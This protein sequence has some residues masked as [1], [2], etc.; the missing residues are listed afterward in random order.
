[1]DSSYNFK[2]YR[3]SKKPSELLRETEGIRERVLFDRLSHLTR[4]GLIVKRTK[5]G[6]P[7]ESYY[8]LRNPEEFIPLKE[9]LD[10]ADLPF[11]EMVKLFS[12]K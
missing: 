7:K 9:L 2:A 6:Y 3:R 1:M 8:Y 4:L 10:S 5:E 12:C 11:K